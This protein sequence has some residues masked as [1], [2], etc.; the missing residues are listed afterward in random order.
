MSEA[1][2]FKV[3]SGLAK[4]LA[5]PGGRTV[6]EAERRAAQGL[7]SHRED[8]LVAIGRIIGELEQACAAAEAG[9]EAHVYERA[10]TLIDLAGF[11]DTGPLYEAGYSLCELSDRMRGA[12]VW[13]W[14]AVEV[15]VKALRLI[16]AGGCKAD[17]NAAVLLQGLRSVLGAFAP[18]A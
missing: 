6:D 18:A 1:R 17:D 12:G 8:T 13:K 4:Q 5:R 15:H 10:A 9:Q 2:T 7:A 11:F 14:P 3:Q 16:H